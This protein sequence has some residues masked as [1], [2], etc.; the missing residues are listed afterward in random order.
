MCFYNKKDLY[1]LYHCSQLINYL[2]HLPI[3]FIGDKI[4]NS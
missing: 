4:N 1:F 3:N 2:D